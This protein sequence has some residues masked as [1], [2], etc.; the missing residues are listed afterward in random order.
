MSIS[1]QE[2]AM[3][4][5]AL[6]MAMGFFSVMV[7]TAI[8]MGVPAPKSSVKQTAA[9]SI[10][11]LAQNSASAG[12]GQ[13]SKLTKKDVLVIFDGKQYRDRSLNTLDLAT[14]RHAERV[15]LAVTPNLSMSAAMQAQKGISAK[16]IVITTLDPNWNQALQEKSN[17]R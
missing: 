14:I 2:N 10:A 11:V 16:N 8:S 3:T 17:A 7:L 9:V 15:V 5:I 4:E 1:S 13:A 6:A 12:S